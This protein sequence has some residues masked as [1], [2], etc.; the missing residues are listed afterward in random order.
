[1]YKD[2]VVDITA[3]APR[4]LM[5]YA[6]KCHQNEIH[7]PLLEC[8]ICLLNVISQDLCCSR[9]YTSFVYVKCL[10]CSRHACKKA[11]VVENFIV[12][13]DIY[14]YKTCLVEQ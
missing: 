8:C 12:I 9:L 6:F 1:M 3:L 10:V 4:N 13:L 14:T 11:R 2:R 7:Y 5:A